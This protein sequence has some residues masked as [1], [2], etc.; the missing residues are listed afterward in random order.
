MD[1]LAGAATVRIRAE[2]EIA[3]AGFEIVGGGGRFSLDEGNCAVM[4]LRDGDMCVM[5][6]ADLDGP[7]SAHGEVVIR[8]MDAGGARIGRSV[9]IRP[10]RVLSAQLREET[11]RR[12][13]DAEERAR[14][15][16]ARLELGPSVTGDPDVGL[17][18]A[19]CPGG[20]ADFAGRCP[21]VAEGGAAGAVV[22]GGGISA[23]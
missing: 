4:P 17:V 11:E 2:G 18:A 7:E 20:A 10:G 21:G 13:E 3:E 1:S 22:F 5:A 14:I 23:K 19:A 16:E 12:L 6:W 9:P 8:G 15:A